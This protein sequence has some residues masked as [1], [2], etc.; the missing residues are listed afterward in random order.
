MSTHYSSS[1]E[2]AAGPKSSQAV[3]PDGGRKPVAGRKH[4]WA[5]AGLDHDIAPGDNEIRTGRCRNLEP[6]DN[7]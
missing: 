5:K 4:G 1:A 3:A 7:C 6:V 2:S